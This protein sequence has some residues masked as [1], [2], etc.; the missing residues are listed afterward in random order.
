[1]A[2]RIGPDCLPVVVEVSSYQI[3][4][5]AKYPLGGQT[6]ITLPN[7][8]LNYLLTWG[9]LGLVLSVMAYRFSRFGLSGSRH[10]YDA[11]GA[12]KKA[13]TQTPQ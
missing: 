11:F 3:E 4:P 12:H 2:Q 10:A 7:N 9:T 13:P 8:H 6:N 5:S 1:M